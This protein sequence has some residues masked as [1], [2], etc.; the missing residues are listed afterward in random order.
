MRRVI[1]ALLTIAVCWFAS[2]AAHA[3][4]FNLPKQVTAGKEFSVTTSGSGD[5]V[6][7]LIG[8][9]AIRGKASASRAVTTKNGI[10]WTRMNSGSTQGAAQFVASLP[11][12]EDEEASVRRVVQ[13]VAAE[14]CNL[15][16][17]AQRTERAIVV[18]TEPVKDCSGNSLPDGTIV[19]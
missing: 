4:E 2:Y 9:R 18:E 17:R 19:T 3:A 15:R 8:P 12:A 16:M 6:L 10:A 13:Q 11:G 1:L 5:G 14:A 7:V